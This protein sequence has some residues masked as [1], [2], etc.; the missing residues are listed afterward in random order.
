MKSVYKNIGRL[1][2]FASLIPAMQVSAATLDVPY[3][4]QRSFLV[5]KSGV[6]NNMSDWCWNACSEMVL[7]YKGTFFTQDAIADYGSQGSNY[8]NWIFSSSPRTTNTVTGAVQPA[9]NGIDLILKNFGGLNSRRYYQALTAAE[10][11]TEIDGGRPAIARLGWCNNVNGAYVNNGGGHFVVL[12]GF[13]GTTVDINDPWPDNGPVM[14]IYTTLARSSGSVYTAN[15]A[16]FKWTHTLALGAS[17]DVCFLIDTTG[18]MG[19]AIDSV[20]AAAISISSNI[21]RLFPDARIAVKDFKD[22]P[23]YSDAGSAYLDEVDTPFTTNQATIA[24]AINPLSADGGGDEPEADYSSLMYTMNNTSWDGTSLGG[25]R[26]NPT[27]RIIII[28]T[29]AP[30]HDPVEPWTGGYSIGDVIAKAT[31]P[32]KEISIFGLAAGSDAVADLETL[33]SGTGGSE[34]DTGY[35]GVAD[36]INQVI[37][38]TSQSTRHPQGVATAPRPK[39]TFDVGNIGMGGIPTGYRIQILKSNELTGTWALYLDKPVTGSSF[40]PSSSLPLGNYRWRLGSLQPATSIM[41][42]AGVLLHTIAAELVYENAYTE[43]SRTA[44][45]VLDPTMLSPTTSS[46]DVFTLSFTPRQKKLA[47]VGRL[48]QTFTWSAGLNATTYTVTIQV[49]NP[50]TKSW[51]TFKTLTVTAPASNP[52]AQTLSVNVLGLKP[53]IHYRW[54]VVSVGSDTPTLD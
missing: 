43:F 4:A 18:S 42:P 24:A 6:T 34:F 2:L 22:N 26:T 16:R 14:Q 51:S 33:A 27:P 35:S 28:A 49:Q 29:D 19:G 20:K 52:L 45:T 25:W 17:L 9:L 21:F 37:T 13:D 5:V 44:G 50:G 12:Y 7:D 46:E 39:F 54:N 10:L 1:L 30:G 23:A 38:Q 8:W 32:G 48:P 40:T 47:M 11:Q 41:S 31:T 15:S 53:N 36:G 3:Y